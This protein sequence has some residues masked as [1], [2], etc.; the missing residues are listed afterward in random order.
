MPKSNELKDHVY[1]I[2]YND[3]LK[4]FRQVE[5]SLY[6]VFKVVRAVLKGD[7]YVCAIIKRTKQEGGSNVD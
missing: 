4:E 7:G 5:P 6:E 2:R 1:W 3:G